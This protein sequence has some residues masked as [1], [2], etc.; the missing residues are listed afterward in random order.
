MSVSNFIMFA[1]FP[2]ASQCV[3]MKNTTGWRAGCFDS[4]YLSRKIG[5]GEFEEALQSARS[6]GWWS[7]S[8]LGSD[9]WQRLHD[10][11]TDEYD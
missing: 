1:K 5:E 6:V 8:V 3:E 4:S 7:D 11:W 10:R 9:Y 2:W